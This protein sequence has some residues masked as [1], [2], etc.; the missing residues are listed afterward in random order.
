M[1]FFVLPALFIRSLMALVVEAINN[2]PNVRYR[3]QGV[4]WGSA[5]VYALATCAIFVGVAL[6]GFL[7]R[8]RDP[9]VLEHKTTADPTQQGVIY[10]NVPTEYNNQYGNVP[11]PTQMGYA[12]TPPGGYYAAPSAPTTYGTPSPQP[13]APAPTGYTVPAGYKLVPATQA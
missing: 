4:A 5:F 6:I 13:N 9:G 2:S 11:Q 1:A 7:F 10:T 12:N 8:P 3:N